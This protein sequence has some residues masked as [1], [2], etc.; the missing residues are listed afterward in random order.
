MA[1]DWLGEPV[2]K[3]PSDMKQRNVIDSQHQCVKSVNELMRSHIPEINQITNSNFTDCSSGRWN[4][5]QPG[6]QSHIHHDGELLN[7]MLIYWHAPDTSYGTTFY[8]SNSINDVFHQF[9]S[10]AGTGYLMLNHV[11]AT[12]HRPLQYHGMLKRVPAKCWRLIT[13]WNFY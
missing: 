2:I 10:V 6:Y 12:G 1:I 3:S 5:C 7:T 11:D 8:N 13:L 9:E 4:L